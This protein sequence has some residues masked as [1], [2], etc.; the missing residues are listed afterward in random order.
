LQIN[1][2]NEKTRIKSVALEWQTLVWTHVYFN[3]DRYTFIQ[4]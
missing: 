1:K 2:M 3:I 4:R